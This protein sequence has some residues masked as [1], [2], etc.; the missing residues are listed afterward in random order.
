MSEYKKHITILGG[1]PAGMAVAFYAHEKGIEYSLFERSNRLGGNCITLE[2]NG[3][4]FD[5]KGSP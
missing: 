2:H 5:S 4:L 3:F 1:G